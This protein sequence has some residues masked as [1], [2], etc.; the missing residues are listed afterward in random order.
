MV[1]P[2]GAAWAPDHIPKQTRGPK[3]PELT[4][5]MLH[6]FNAGCG[7]IFEPSLPPVPEELGTYGPNTCEDVQFAVHMP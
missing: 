1:S 3:I 6:S 7:P 4:N 2:T 5:E